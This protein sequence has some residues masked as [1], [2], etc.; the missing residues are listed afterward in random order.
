MSKN[1]KPYIAPPKMPN[2]QRQPLSFFNARVQSIPIDVPLEF[3][4]YLEINNER[5]LFRNRKETI[6][7]ERMTNLLRHDLKQVQVPS[8]QRGAYL[9]A[10]RN[11][12]RNDTLS[13]QVR[14][15]FI[16]ES[17]FNHMEDLF[18]KDD[19]KEIVVDC[20][21]LVKEMVNFI[22]DDVEAA[23]KLMQ[24]S[25]HDYYT[26]NHS[27]NVA[28]YTIA[29]AQ[30]VFGEDKELLLTA[31]LG[32][33]LHDIGKRRVGIEIINK[34]TKL[35]PDEWEEIK[36]HPAYGLDV[37]KKVDSIPEGTKNIVY[38]HHENM[39]GSGYPHGLK[40]EEISKVARIA[41]MADV[42]DALT[43]KRAY[44]E[45]VGA[46]EA[47]QIMSSMQPGKFDPSLFKN[48]DTNIQKKAAKLTI[49]KDVDPCSE[50]GTK[51]KR[52]G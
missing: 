12:I 32:G 7:A 50:H 14:G 8:E 35:D 20:K 43:T 17:A 47:L 36:K 16:K 19:V 52:T 45:A 37:I 29:I 41:A 40:E 30:R 46:V 51:I 5:V 6:T 15:K 44:K 22:S 9:A 49:D 38:Q 34:P 21:H 18:T 11:I 10:M 4:I 39:D 28:V 25:N 27:V 13:R 31:G 23:V 33:L 3:D 1:H 24:L 2:P 42:F 26:Y 48:F